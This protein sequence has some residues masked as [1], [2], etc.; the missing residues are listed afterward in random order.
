MGHTFPYSLEQW[1]NK[2][3]LTYLPQ[4]HQVPHKAEHAPGVPKRIGMGVAKMNSW[5]PYLGLFYCGPHSHPSPSIPV[6]FI[7][8]FASSQPFKL[9]SQ[10]SIFRCLLSI[11]YFLL[12]LLS[13]LMASNLSLLFPNQSSAQTTILSFTPIGPAACRTCVHLSVP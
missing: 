13:R 7:T 12:L 9:C 1:Q 5:F 8:S 6:L 4:T 11:Y 2:R 10:G 3:M